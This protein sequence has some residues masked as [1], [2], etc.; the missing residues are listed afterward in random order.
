MK[1]VLP[2]LSLLV[3]VLALPACDKGSTPAAGSAVLE[4]SDFDQSCEV[5]TDCVLVPAGELCGSCPACPIEPIAASA[6]PDFRA[7]LDDVDCRT[8]QPRKGFECEPCPMRI[9]RCDDGTC[10]SVAPSN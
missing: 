1:H 5:D 7:R 8:T 3:V 6:E 10:T 2:G 9:P 4:A